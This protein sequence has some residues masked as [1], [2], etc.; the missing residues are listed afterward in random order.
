MNMRMVIYLKEELSADAVERLCQHLAGLNVTLG[1][2]PLF[3]TSESLAI[4]AKLMTKRNIDMHITAQDLM[5]EWPELYTPYKL[6]LTTAKVMAMVEP[7]IDG[8]RVLVGLLTNAQLGAYLC[9]KRSKNVSTLY[10]E[11]M[12][13]QVE[14][15]RSALKRTL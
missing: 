13:K 9:E 7:Q 8:M 15:Q 3:W 10:L 4:E 6:E 2:R 5:T 1:H 11:R 14:R 12:I